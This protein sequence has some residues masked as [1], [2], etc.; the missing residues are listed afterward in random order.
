MDEQKRASMLDARDK[1]A[2]R[3][4]DSF[5]DDAGRQFKRFLDANKSRLKDLGSLV[6]IDGRLNYRKWQTEEGQTR[7]KLD[8][9]ANNVQFMPANR[10]G[11]KPPAESG[12]PPK[13][14]AGS[15]EVPF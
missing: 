6:L 4:R 14:A 7:T 8:V 5:L 12:P 1:D 9:V 11:G 3:K 13:D 10:S 15:G 2:G